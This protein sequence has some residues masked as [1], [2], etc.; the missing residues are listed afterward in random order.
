VKDGLKD[1]AP[2]FVLFLVSAVTLAL[3]VKRL[4]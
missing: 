1:Y 3:E 4:K 2:A